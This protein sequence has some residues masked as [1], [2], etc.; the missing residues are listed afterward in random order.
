VPRTPRYGRDRSGEALQVDLPL[1]AFSLVLLVANGFFVAAEFA[2]VKVRTA[3]L[4]PEIERGSRLAG[5]AKR[6][7]EHLDGYLSATRLGITLTSLGLGWVGQPAVARLFAPLF[8]ALDLPAGVAQ[9]LAVAIGFALVTALHVIVGQV[10]PKA[11]AVARPVS[12]SLAVALPMRAFHL[13]ARPAVVALDVASNGLL[14]L[15]G[16]PPAGSHGLAVPAEE[17]RQITAESVAGGEITSDQ[18]EMLSNVFSFSDRVAHEIMVPR[19]K[20]HGIDLQLPIDESLVQ[21]LKH[22]HSRYPLYDGDLDHVVGVLHL[23]DLLPHV[24]DGTTPS[25]LR[26]L[27]REPLFVPGA[28]SAQRLLQTFQRRR[29]HLAIVLDEYGGVDGITT[30]EDVLEELVGDIQDE[31]DVE[32]AWVEETAEG[33]VVDGGMLV[34]EVADLI[35]SDWEA[36][37]TDATTLAGYLME[38]LERVPKLGDEVV[39]PGGW[40][41]RVSLAAHR[42]AERVELTRPKPVASD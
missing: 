21:A 26:S 3:Q 22:G 6:M 8:A 38:Q 7:L 19:P 32:Q 15:V 36:F 39:L 34:D 30:L 24:I 10:L 5:S 11:L 33:Y 28:M 35:G 13:V 16:L 42:T 23:K 20:V 29:T 14:K 18:G 31:Y 2:L 17:L 40:H 4:D 27:A 9:A 25:D 41:A 12:T 37:D 1:I